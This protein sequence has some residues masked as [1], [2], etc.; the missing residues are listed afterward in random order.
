MVTGREK[1]DNC[2]FRGNITDLYWQPFLLPSRPWLKLLQQIQQTCEQ[3]WQ[4]FVQHL[5]WLRRP[6]V[7]SGWVFKI[8]VFF[9]KNIYEKSRSS[10]KHFLEFEC[11]FQRPGYLRKSERRVDCNV[12]FVGNVVNLSHH[13]LSNFPIH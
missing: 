5:Q 13:G 7:R 3:P 11:L 1:S 8:R 10:I 12:I 2:C 4:H 9:S 6:H